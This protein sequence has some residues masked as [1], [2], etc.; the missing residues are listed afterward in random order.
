MREG[1]TGSGLHKC[2]KKWN[3]PAFP[4]TSEC[5]AVVQ[6]CLKSVQDWDVDYFKDLEAE[7]A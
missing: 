3:S 7:V 1:K 4:D 2:I 6:A 5:K